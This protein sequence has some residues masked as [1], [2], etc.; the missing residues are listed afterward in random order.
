PDWG[1]IEG[2]KPAADVAAPPRVEAAESEDAPAILPVSRAVTGDSGE[3]INIVGYVRSEH[4]IGES[5]RLWC[6]AASAVGLPFSV[7][8]FNTNNNSRTTDDTWDHKL[9]DH[10]EHWINV[11]HVNADQMP[12]VRTTLGDGFLRGHYNVGFWHW[13]LPE[14]PDEWL[15]AFDL[16]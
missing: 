2:T 9:A 4:G 12:A 15:G 11:I 8:D 7:H 13:E 16:V 3:G 5:A 14:F 1:P 10:N 6:R